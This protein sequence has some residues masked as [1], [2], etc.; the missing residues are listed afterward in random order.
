VFLDRFCDD[1]REV[2]WF[3]DRFCD[4]RREVFFDLSWEEIDRCAVLRFSSAADGTDSDDL[5]LDLPARPRPVDLSLDL[6]R[7]ERKEVA[8]GSSSS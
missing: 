2:F 1:R 6:D 4:D 5:S 8:V 7:P 3:F